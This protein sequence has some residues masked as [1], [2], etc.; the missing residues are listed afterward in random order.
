MTVGFPSKLVVEFAR[1]P[2]AE[3]ILANSTTIN[4]TLIDRTILT[5]AGVVAM[6]MVS[7]GVFA[8]EVYSNRWPAKREYGD[9]AITR[10]MDAVRS[11]ADR[12]KA[13]PNR[14]VYH[15]RPPAQWMNDPNG[16]IFH[17]GYYHVFYQ[18][19]PHGDRWGVE[20]TVWGHARSRDLVHWEHLPI[21]IPAPAGVRRINSGCTAINGAGRPLAFF[22]AVFKG[23]R[24]REIWAAI[25]DDDMI[26][27]KFHPANPIMTF[28]THG[29]PRYKKWDAPFIFHEGGRTFMILSSCYLEDGRF[30]IP[31]YE[32]DD[33]ELVRWEYRGLLHELARES[34]SPYLECPMIFR[35]GQRWA[36]I[37]QPVNFGGASFYTGVFD[38]GTLRFRAR[39]QGAFLHGA[40]PTGK[41]ADGAKDRG[42]APT[43]I[44]QEPQGRC[45]MFG[46]QSSFLHGRGWAGCMG[47]PRVLSIDQDGHPRQL[48]VQELQKLRG[49]HVGIERWVLDDRARLVAG[50]AGDTLEIVATNRQIDGPACLS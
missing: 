41:L 40:G 43:S 25:G 20:N 36:I 10:A 48:P 9:P 19:N 16:A 18:L 6:V 29:G 49:E 12:L 28:E 46:W 44:Y 37:G 2:Y 21:A 11:A 5:L 22:P 3:G 33:P 23:D 8:G 1:I 45:L 42:L 34:D 14:P 4:G 13:D 32:T 15:F 24:P 39:G 50:A 38:I 27:W 35:D 26:E 7:S 17:K 30:V 31:I 47:L